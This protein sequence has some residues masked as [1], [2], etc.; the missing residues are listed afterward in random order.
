MKGAPIS[1]NPC[2]AHRHLEVD[3]SCTCA[4]RT[5]VEHEDSQMEGHRTVNLI[6]WGSWNLAIVTLRVKGT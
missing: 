1:E 5:G 3:T 4:E 2:T 6:K